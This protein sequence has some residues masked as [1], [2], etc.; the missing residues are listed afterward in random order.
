MIGQARNKF[1]K[2]LFS[3]NESTVKPKLIEVPNDN[4]Q[5]DFICKKILEL[6]EQGIDLSKIAVLMRSGWH[7]NDLEL[8]L[9][10]QNIPFIKMG[11]FK[12]I[13]TSHIKDVVCYFRILYNTN[14]VISWT[15]LLLMLEGCGPGAAKKITDQVKANSNNPLTVLTQHQK[16][17]TPKTLK[18]S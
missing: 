15:R 14:D 12:F 7:S 16:K 1:K 17:N 11:G 13:E 4:E 3:T 5:S 8:E 18:L 9:K 6:R 10:S 2:H